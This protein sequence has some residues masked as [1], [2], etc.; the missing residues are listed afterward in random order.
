MS[1][2]ELAHEMAL[3]RRGASLLEYE[4]SPMS[5]NGYFTYELRGFC[6][7]DYKI[8]KC[9]EQKRYHVAQ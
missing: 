7:S 5:G 8:K 3:D 1:D 6:G 4:W 9:L 2:G